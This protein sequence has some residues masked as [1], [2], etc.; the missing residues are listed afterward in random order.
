MEEKIKEIVASFIKVPAGEIGPA[1][2]ID[3]SV[4]QSSIIL[5][6]M[7]ARLAE[8]G[9]VI[10]NYAAV[11]VFGD[12]NGT[13]VVASA[14]P[15]IVYP[16]EATPA[17]VGIDIEEIGALPRTAD[18]RKEEF[19]KMNFTPE[20]IAYCILQPDPYSSF[21]GLFAAKEALVKAGGFDRSRSFNKVEIEHSPEGKPQYPGFG[22]SISHSGGMAVAVAAAG[23]A[24]PAAPTLSTPPAPQSGG[25]AW[26]SWLALLLAAV[27]LTL[28]LLH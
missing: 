17:S 2:R 22:I 26:I 5:H 8:E 11:K 28:V 9:V 1:T 12:L 19:Y 6:R 3:R 18:F 27:A 7:Y 16:S 10:E 23:S 4:I 20:E 13:P 25:N 14:L 21:A 24:M 15:E